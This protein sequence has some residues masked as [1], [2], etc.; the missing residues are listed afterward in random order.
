MP[1]LML[2]LNMCVLRI[3]NPVWYGYLDTYIGIANNI[4]VPWIRTGKFWNMW[5]FWH[6]NELQRQQS[7]QAVDLLRIKLRG[8]PCLYFLYKFNVRMCL[9]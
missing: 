4:I 1:L 5:I 8:R 9:F 2:V 7:N 6:R 3:F